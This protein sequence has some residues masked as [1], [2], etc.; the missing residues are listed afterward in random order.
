VYAWLVKDGDKEGI[1]KFDAWL[2]RPPAGMA[3]GGVADLPEWQ[4]DA[5]ADQF[6][7]QMAARQKRQ[8]T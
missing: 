6:L 5:M 7:A 8:D 4:A 3:R 2:Y 1:E